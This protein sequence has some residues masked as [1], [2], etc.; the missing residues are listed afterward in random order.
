LREPADVAARS[1]ALTDALAH[2]LAPDAP[3]H[4]LDLGTGTGSNVRY[5]LQRLPPQQ[6]WLVVDRDRALLDELL[7]RTTAWA[8]TLGHEARVTDRVCH[9][10]GAALECRIEAVRADMGTLDR[11]LCAG[12]DLVT[13]SALL[14]LVSASWLRSLAA[15]CRS[16]GASALFALTYNGRFTCSPAE[17]E[18]ELVRALMN[19]HQKRDKGLGGPAEGPDAVTS[20][21]R[22][23][24]DEGFLVKRETTN[25]QLGPGEGAL[26]EELINGWLQ[27]AIE[28]EP[29][30]SAILEDWHARRLAHVSSGI[31]RIVVGHDDI[32][33]LHPNRRING[34]RVR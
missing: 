26:Q 5:L 18:D 10:E 21:E 4:I 22:A 14:D 28:V 7:A 29:E 33:A 1:T 13:A 2:T 3:V 31:S 11:S 32:L 24:R 12:R 8:V 25:W 30:R 17:P 19:R 16:A 23:F 6:Q 27:A 9:I 20:A 34:T 15:C